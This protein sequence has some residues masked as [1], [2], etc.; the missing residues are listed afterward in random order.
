MSNMSTN[1]TL[2]L[3]TGVNRDGKAITEITLTPPTA[4]HLR[5][6]KL[7]DVLQFDVDTLAKLLPRISQPTLTEQDVYQFGLKDLAATTE[8][9]AGFL[10]S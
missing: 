7:L 1:K 2:T 5:G 4:G 9:L 3:N 10:D 8:V 6:L